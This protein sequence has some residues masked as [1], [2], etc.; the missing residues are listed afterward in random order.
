MVL[1]F[2]PL[3]FTFVCPTELVQFS[4]RIKEFRDINCEVVGCSVDSRFSH[5]TYTKLERKKGGLGKMNIPL[6]SDVSK[7]IA[8]AYDCLCD[9]GADDGVAFRAT[10]IIDKN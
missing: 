2:Y 10:Y 4:D 5:M 1:F 8:T 7:K 3:N 6:L 9:V